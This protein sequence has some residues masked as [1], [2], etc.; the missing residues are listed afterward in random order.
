MARREKIR[1]VTREE[2]KALARRQM[3]EQG[4][5]ALSL[6]AIARAMELTPP[7]LYRY[8]GSRDE[9]IT[10]LIVDAYGEL[11]AA[12][13]A[14]VA[15]VPE[16]R[17]GAR[18]LAGLRAYR[19]WALAAPGDFQLIFGNPIP[20]YV[21]PA[22]VTL[23]AARRSLAVLLGVLQ[24]AHAAG[25]LREPPPGA[26][27]MALPAVPGSPERLAPA[28]LAHGLSGWARVHGLAML[29]LFDHIQPIVPD[30]TAWFEREARAIVH[31][32]GLDPDG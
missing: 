21:A 29:E 10:A 20:G 15:A 32:A 1:T 22:E 5:A 14:A 7:A 23:P 9:L 27:A 26:P 3:A 4:T 13:A 18:L 12:L 6:A 28:V 24:A 8:Y 2:I 25:A 11:A 16:G 30:T 31:E 17:Y 19:A